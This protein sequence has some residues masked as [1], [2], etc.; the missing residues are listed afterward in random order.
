MRILH[1]KWAA[2]AMLLTTLLVSGTASQEIPS[3]PASTFTVTKTTD[4]ND[5]I[6]DADCSLREAILAANAQVGADS[7]IVPAGIYTLTIPGTD[8]DAGATGDLDI[9]GDVTLTGAGTALT[10]IDG[11]GIDRVIEVTGTVT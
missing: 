4:T 11:G 6:C 5:G 1:R 8:E 10:V 9:R 3:T 2:N 7:V